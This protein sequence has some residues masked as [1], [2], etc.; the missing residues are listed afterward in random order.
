MLDATVI[1]PTYD[2][3]MTLH[4]AVDSALT[5]TGVDHEVVVVDD[6][7][8]QRPALPQHPRLRLVELPTNRGACAARNAGVRAARGRWVTTL[9]DDDLLTP[10]HLELALHAILGSRLPAPV[11][12]LSGVALVEADGRISGTRYPPTL[13]RGRAYSLEPRPPGTAFGLRCTLVVERDV[14]LAIGGWDETFASRQHTELFLRLNP[15][16]S[17][18]GIPVVTY[19]RRRHDELRVSGDPVRRD[20]SQRQLEDV[21]RV[22]LRRYPAGHVDM[23]LRQGTKLWLAGDRRRATSTWGRSFR[24]HPVRTVG[25]ARSVVDDLRRGRA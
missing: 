18:Q 13:P 16:C 21:H 3:S 9:D 19:D 25:G 20:T 7:S 8:S 17:L 6:G 14:L 12:S 11:A 15:V 5:Q 23:L 2:R 1:V 10:D 22:L 24:V 4:E